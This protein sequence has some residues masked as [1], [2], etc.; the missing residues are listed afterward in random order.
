MYFSIAPVEAVSQVH[1]QFT[2][3]PGAPRV[4]QAPRPAGLRHRVSIALHG[5]ADRLESAP[6]PAH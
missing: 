6:A 5:L 1:R 2:E 3:M 4:R